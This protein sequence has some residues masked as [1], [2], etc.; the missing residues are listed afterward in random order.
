MPCHCPAIVRDDEGEVPRL[1]GAA[2]EP[3]VRGMESRTVPTVRIGVERRREYAPKVGEPVFEPNV[4]PHATARIIN[5]RREHRGAE[6]PRGPPGTD[7]AEPRARRALTS[8]Y[9][10]AEG[11]HLAFCQLFAVV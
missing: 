1:P 5:A 4:R 11:F 2:D 8:A 9:L 7:G 10:I 6:D 3:R